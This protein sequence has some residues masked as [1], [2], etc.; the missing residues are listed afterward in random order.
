MCSG[1]AHKKKLAQKSNSSLRTV[2]TNFVS[3]ATLPIARNI[4]RGLDNNLCQTFLL[5][6]GG[7]RGI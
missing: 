6:Q 3:K 4:S 5:N 2:M 1:F 7:W